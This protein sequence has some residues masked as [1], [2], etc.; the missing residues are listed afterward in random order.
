MHKAE[1]VSI[2]CYNYF[3]QICSISSHKGLGVIATKDFKKGDFVC[4]YAG[5]LIS[6]QDGIKREKKLLR[7]PQHDNSKCY[8]YFFMWK[9]KKFW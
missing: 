6:G 2:I 9:D 3:T 7:N 4:E 1:F 5:E 8:M